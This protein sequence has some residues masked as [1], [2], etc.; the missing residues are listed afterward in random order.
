[1]IQTFLVTGGTGEKRRL[2]IQDTCMAWH[3]APFDQSVLQK[4]DEEKQSI[5]IGDV[6]AWQ[7]TLSFVPHGSPYTVG[8][9][10]DAHT[11]TTEAQQALLKTLEEPPGHVRI[12]LETDRTSMLLPTILSRSTIIIV[13]KLNR[14]VDTQKTLA[15]LGALLSPEYGRVISNLDAHVNNKNDAAVFLDDLLST[16]HASLIAPKTMPFACGYGRAG[17]YIRIILTA[18]NMLSAN[19]NYRLVLDEMVFAFLALQSPK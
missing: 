16:F 13:G 1:M 17:N 5:G 8:I 2:H 12:L 15:L 6:R 11:L 14:I 18:Q 19:V 3:V 7:K 9:I 10:K 4:K